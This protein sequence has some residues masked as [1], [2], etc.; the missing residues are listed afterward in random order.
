MATPGE[1]YEKL[2]AFYLGRSY[3]LESRQ[4]QDDLVLYDS[5][6]LTT[7]AVCVGMTGSGKTGLCIGLLE[8]AAIDGIPALVIDPKGD[9]T[10]LMLTF[11]D[12]QPGDFRPWINED[13][14]RR[15]GMTSDQFAKNQAELWKNGLAKWGQTGERIR[16]LRAAADVSVYTPG[17]DAGLPLSILSSF[18]APPPAVLAEADLYRDRISTTATSLLGLLG[19]DADPIRSREH[20]LISTLLDGV[21]RQGQSLDLGAL[22]HLVQNPPITKIGVLDLESFYPSKDRFELAMALNNL[23]AAPGF[24]TWMTGEPVDVDRLLYGP[25]GRP[26]ISI[27]SIAHLSD[28]ERMFFVS[29]LLN[30]ALGWMR[31]CSGTTSLRALIYMDEIFGYMPPVAEPPSKK[32]MLTLLKQ[33][34]AFGV[35]L[36]LATQ[37]PVDLDYKGLSNCGTWLLGRL[38]TERDKNRVLD[39]L[40]GVSAGS[41]ASFDRGTMEETLA[42]LGKRVFL[43]HNVHE[44]EPVVFHTRWA[45]SYL[46][47]PLTRDQIRM[48]MRPRKEVEQPAAVPPAAIPP[49]AGPFAASPSV[50][51]PIPAPAAAAP[52]A[53]AV[54]PPSATT[55]GPQV[56]VSQQRPVL[57]PDIPQAFLPVH[58]WASGSDVLCRPRLIGVSHVHFVDT[59]RGLEADE[60]L[61]LIVPLDEGISGID[62]DD[63][64]ALELTLDDLGREPFGPARFGDVPAKAASAKSYASWNKSLKNWL[65]R[66]RRFDLLKSKNLGEVSCP[67]ESEREF[68]IRIAE[69]AREERDLR[70]EKLRKKYVPKFDSLRERIRRAELTVQKEKEQATGAKTQAVI[71]LGATLL[72][73][74]FGRKTLS[75]T[76]IGKATTTVRGVGRSSRQAQDVARA[77]ENLE[78]YEVKLQDLDRDFQSEVE[79]LRD[80]LDPMTEELQVL[81]LKPRKTDVDVRLLA[82]AWAPFVRGA[83]GGLVPAWRPPTEA[84][85]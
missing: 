75:S 46:R 23:L 65:Y 36:V 5:K 45:M 8:E 83:D 40:E 85:F 67:G 29:L 72:S 24:S 1:T 57:P 30:Q 44:E 68:R 2:G 28:A 54:P 47:G 25:D 73:A 10:N 53:F 82:L 20:I 6:D 60:H 38:Q 76:T 66:H 9:L 18:A 43:M 58:G 13:D 15:Q 27:C 71:S 22:I 11:P 64:A 49:A 52:T 69:R 55:L 51:A 19:I 62:W 80:K 4:L 21:W 7:H 31:S 61:T 42:G 41:G 14:A 3:D 63:A 16:R 59:R 50:A 48:L 34:R 37:N 74:V 77:R 26:R 32:A 79:Q 81:T 39:G 33:A 70:I 56:A 84:N 12:L 17:S 35:G 78:A